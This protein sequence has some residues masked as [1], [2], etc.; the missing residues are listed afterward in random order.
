MSDRYDCVCHPEV[1]CAL[2]YAL[3]DADERVRA[4]AADEI[5]DQ[6]RK[7]PC[8]CSQKV[9]SALTC[10][11]A[12]CHWMVRFQ[13][14]QALKRCG[15]CIVDACHVG[16]CDMNCCGSACHAT[17]GAAVK[18]PSPAVPA[19]LPPGE[20][21]APSAAPVPHQDGGAAPAPSAYFKKPVIRQTSATLS[22][23]KR[24][25]AAL[26]ELFD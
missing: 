10:A 25:L 5:G 22:P 12:D 6:L 17:G 26:I 19:D 1:M 4:K 14:K 23:A 3:N 16:C 13:A 20:G 11:L 21:E 8:C 2:I 9:V 18:N 7:N 15:Y 24:G